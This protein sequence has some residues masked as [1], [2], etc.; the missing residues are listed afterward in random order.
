MSVSDEDHRLQIVHAILNVQS[1]HNPLIQLVVGTSEK[2][3]CAVYD[4]PGNLSLLVGSDF[5]RGPGFKLFQEGWLSFYDLGYYL[6]VANLSDI[7]AM[8]GVP[9]GVTT[10]VRYQKTLKD[11]EF[12][13]L[14]EGMKEAARVYKTPI[15]GG[16]IGGYQE[17]VL[18]AT[19]F[20]VT[21]QGR[22]L[23]RRGTQVGDVLCL[24]GTPGLPS[25]ALAYFTKARQ[26]GL[27]LSESEEE[28]LLASW[29]RPV[30]HIEV[31]V[32][33]V[34]SKVVH[35]CQDVSDG[36][37][38]TIDQ[39]AKA[40]DVSFYLY[41]TNIPIH[42]ITKKVAAFLGVDAI[43]L[44]FSASVDFNLLFTLAEKDFLIL[45][46]ILRRDQNSPPIVILGRARSGWEEFLLEQENGQTK[47]IP[48]TSWNHQTGD[49]TEVILG[50]SENRSL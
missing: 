46:K 41:E 15:V 3:D 45:Q 16:D 4:F 11:E 42:P 6:I 43:A 5:I 7:A 49:V 44:A 47:S 36:M 12:A 29:R 21:E 25:T 37:K 31:G 50:K 30:A 28:V 19:A 38:A 22:Y 27:R 24:T 39:L 32:A 1:L 26:E 13:Q 8:G 17:T 40:S 34:A 2:D 20:G 33:L 14:F 18:A 35:A 48:G 10:I 23:K 9:I